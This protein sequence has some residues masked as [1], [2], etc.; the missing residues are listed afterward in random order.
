MSVQSLDY[1]ACE[2]APKSDIERR[3][4]R[5]AGRAERYGAAWSSSFGFACLSSYTCPTWQPFKLNKS[6]KNKLAFFTLE[7]ALSVWS[8]SGKNL[9]FVWLSVSSKK[10]GTRR[11]IRLDELSSALLRSVMRRSVRHSGR[12]VMYL[13]SNVFLC[14]FGRSL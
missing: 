6:Y 1:L 11:I 2:Q 4:N 5:R 3:E 7:D 9:L 12:S 13:S 14:H 10:T 8:I